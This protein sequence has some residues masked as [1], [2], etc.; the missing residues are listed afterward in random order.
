MSSNTIGIHVNYWYV[1][2]ACWSLEA[3][4][5]EC[6]WVALDA[7]SE[8]SMKAAYKKYVAPWMK[9]LSPRSQQLLMVSLAHL[10]NTDFDF[11]TILNCTQDIEM[12]QPKDNRLLFVWLWEV[13]YPGMA[14]SDAD[15]RGL[16]EE[17]DP[18]KAN[19][20]YGTIAGN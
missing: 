12:N 6:D 2:A 5:G 16:V 3:S 14:A 15:T 10:L 7:N 13:L 18:M 9:G 19:Q 17:N 20:F 4:V 11:Q 1:V 8:L